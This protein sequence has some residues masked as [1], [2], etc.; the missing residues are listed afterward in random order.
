MTTRFRRILSM[1]VLGSTIAGLTSTSA[2]SQQP[3]DVPR[4]IEQAAPAPPGPALLAGCPAD[5]QPFYPCAKEKIK[6][7][8]PPR[9]PDGKPDFQGYW[10]ANR[11][12]F[13]IEAHER[14]YAYQGGP[15]LV[16]D[17]ADGR[18]GATMGSVPGSRVSLMMVSRGR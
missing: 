18:P 13:N 5:P 8:N 16:V 9:T 3:R 7:F 1:L 6:T 4:P 12:A 14:D 11:Q 10:N 15:T 2:A 17:P